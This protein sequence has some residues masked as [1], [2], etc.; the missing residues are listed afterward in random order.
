MRYEGEKT[1][2]LILIKAFRWHSAN[3]LEGKG[4]ADYRTVQEARFGRRTIRGFGRGGVRIHG[5]CP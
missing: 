4:A 1:L 3:L 2:P 5:G